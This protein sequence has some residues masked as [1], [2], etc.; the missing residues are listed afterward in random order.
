MDKKKG[1]IDG[2]FSAIPTK[3]KVRKRNRLDDSQDVEQVQKMSIVMCTNCV[4]L[5]A[6]KETQG[7]Q[8]QFQ[9]GLGSRASLVETWFRKR[10]DVLHILRKTQIQNLSPERMDT[11]MGN[12]DSTNQER[13]EN[14]SLCRKS[15][16][17]CTDNVQTHEGGKCHQEAARL[18]KS[19]NDLKKATERTLSTQLLVIQTCMKA[20]YW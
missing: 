12:W 13:Y 11:S 15:S 6:S 19:G 17:V 9:P 5:V 18:M 8:S 7:H 14:V 1:S 3:K 10:F 4:L 16:C 2:Y 20:M